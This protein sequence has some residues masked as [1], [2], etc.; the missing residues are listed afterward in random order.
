MATVD[1]MFLDFG[2]STAAP[3]DPDFDKV[4]LL[5]HGD[6]VNGGTIIDSSG[7]NHTATVTGTPAI[8]TSFS[9]W[10][11]GALLFDATAGYISEGTSTDW[12]LGSGDWTIEWWMGSFDWN[13]V[14]L[15]TPIVCLWSTN[16]GEG[17]S[18]IASININNRL[19]FG[20]R[21]SGASNFSAVSSSAMTGIGSS[22]R[23]CAIVRNGSNLSMYFDGVSEYS[24]SITGAIDSATGCN[25]TIG[26]TNYSG[27]QYLNGYLDDLRITK[28]KARYTAA[29]TPPTGPFPDG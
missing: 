13:G 22:Y 3:T 15:E 20:Y 1:M 25:L 16:G 17:L 19:Q 28:G 23:H 26:G 8:E 4:V 24:G 21:K 6:G 5:L 29:F 2:A 12:Q 27:N 18:W 14:A 10:G 7:S 9:K 11:T